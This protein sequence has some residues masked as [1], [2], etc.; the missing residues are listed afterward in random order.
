[1]NSISTS[2]IVPY[3]CE[4]MYTLVNDIKAYPDFLPWCTTSAIHEQNDDELKASL[5][6]CVKGFTQSFTTHN[7]MQKN[8]MIESKLIEG[9][10]KHL[11]SFWRFEAHEEST[12]AN[13]RSHIFFDIEFE[14]SN[15]L[16]RMAMEPFF[17][18][19]A[20]TMVGAF[21]ERAE[22]LYARQ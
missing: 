6:I 14:F 12:E 18:K 17:D 5:T 2:R 11:E 15:R 21:L 7:R 13:P 19:V 16:V 1:M 8:K 9:P 20:E 3:T 4:E 10:L 22:S